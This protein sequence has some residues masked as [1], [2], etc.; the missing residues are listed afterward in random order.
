MTDGTVLGTVFAAIMLSMAATANAQ[1]NPLEP[2]ERLIGGE[3]HLENTYQE[4]EWGVGRQSVKARSYFIVDGQAKL[5][6]EG[7]WYWHPGLQA[8]K[9]VFTAIDMPVVVFDYTTRFEGNTMLNDLKAYS[10]NG[11]ETVF[12]ETWQ[13]ADNS[14]FEWKLTSILDDG[15]EAV[16]SGPYT[17]TVTTR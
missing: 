8:I 4:F 1:P 6:S 16:M 10:E 13:F 7:A 2:F 5:V 11:N 14:Q 3:W 12:K 9:G 15:S 17:R